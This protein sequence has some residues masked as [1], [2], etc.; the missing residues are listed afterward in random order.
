[1]LWVQITEKLR[2]MSGLAR[3]RD[4]WRLVVFH[5]SAGVAYV[6]AGDVSAATQAGLLQFVEEARRG[7]VPP[8]RLRSV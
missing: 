7:F 8:T 4:G 5:L 3:D 1:M 2:V 6:Y